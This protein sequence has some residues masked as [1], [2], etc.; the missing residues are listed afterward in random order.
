MQNVMTIKS[1][2]RCFEMTSGLKINF[3]KSKLVSLEIE[4]REIM[5]L[6]GLLNC[7]V[8]RVPFIYLGLPVGGN[9]RRLGFWDPV[10]AKLRGRLTQ[11]RQKT[12]S[13]GGRLTLI[14]SVLSSIPLFYLSFFRLPRG[15]LNKCNHI[16]RAFLWGGLE[17][18]NK[19]AWVK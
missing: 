9:P 10:V 12:L 7:K 8:Q 11:W 14:A 6:A 16:M 4:E 13:F 18:K 17:C 1:V 19:V 3:Y 5:R 2:L 15:V